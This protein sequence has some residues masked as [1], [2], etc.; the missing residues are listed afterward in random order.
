MRESESPEIKKLQR[1]L[2][3]LEKELQ[4]LAGS[5]EK[6]EQN[7]KKLMIERIQKMFYLIQLQRENK[8]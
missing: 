7:Y 4:D 8:K 3:R 2:Q 5:Y 1:E 6:S